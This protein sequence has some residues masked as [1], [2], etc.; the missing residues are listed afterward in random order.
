VLARGSVFPGGRIGWL[1]G[2]WEELCIEGQGELIGGVEDEIIELL[3]GAG[4]NV[5]GKG[6]RAWGW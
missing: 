2:W 6:N 5:G 1:F 3:V 4:G